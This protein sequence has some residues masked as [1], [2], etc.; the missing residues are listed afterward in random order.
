MLKLTHMPNQVEVLGGSH[1]EFSLFITNP[2]LIRVL[3]THFYEV[4]NFEYPNSI[5]RPS[6]KKQ[7]ILIAWKRQCFIID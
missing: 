5:P 2:A 1:T 6:S 4:S 7:A 3:R